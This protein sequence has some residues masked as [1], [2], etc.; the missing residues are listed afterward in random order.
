LKI[1]LKKYL[2]YSSVFAVFS[3]AFF[4]RFIIDLKLFYLIILVNYFLLFK[5]KAVSINKLFITIIGFI[6]LHAIIFYTYI[7]IPLY[8]MLSQIIGITITCVYFYNLIKLYTKEELINLYNRLSVIIAIIG[9]PLYF[10]RINLNVNPD[11]RFSSLL[12]EPA[13][14]AI[15]VIPACY[16]FLKTKQ[17]K[18]FSIIFLSLILTE[19]SIA[20]L[21]CALMFT[22][23]YFRFSRLKYAFGIVPF[24]F[25]ILYFVYNN[26]EKVK[27]RFDDTYESLKVINTGKFNERTN[28]STYALLSN[29][30]IAKSN[31]IEHPLGTGIGSHYFMY[32]NKYDKFMRAPSY[33][34]TLKLDKINSKDAASLFIRLFSEFGIFGILIVFFF[35]YFVLKSFQDNNLIFEQGVG[36][37]FLLKLFRDGHYFP[38]EF[39]FFIILFYFSYINYFKNK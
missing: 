34:K 28:L 18:Y 38:P 33:I 2:L 10:L 9:Y 3:E 29:F 17:Y 11:F 8:F 13:H 23:P 19:S 1:N 5:I 14:Y 37:Y 35:L 16:Y 27:M 25:M 21:G 39:F 30:Y 36:I 31:F 24:V 22:L 20:Y 6:F 4:F 26:N 7:G 15:V 32:T 12:T